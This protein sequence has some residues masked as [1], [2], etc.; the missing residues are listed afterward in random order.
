MSDSLIFA[1]MHKLT[2][3][4]KTKNSHEDL[5]CDIHMWIYT[6]MWQILN[7]SCHEIHQ[8]MSLQ[9]FL[10]T[11]LKRFTVRALPITISHKCCKRRKDNPLLV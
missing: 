5:Q 8:N 10:D 4:H 2:V 6:A 3:S 11:K 1:L 7:L 9:K